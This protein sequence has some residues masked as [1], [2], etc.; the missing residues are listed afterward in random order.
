MKKEN[1]TIRESNFELL[2]IISMWLIILYHIIHHGNMIN[3]C[4]NETLAK[5]LRIIL[6]ATLVHVNSFVILTGY[7]QCKSNFKLKKLINLIFQ[8]LF[9]II[10]IYLIGLKLGLITNL[11]NI[12]LINRLSINAI[13][14]YW[15]ITNYLIL[16]IFSDYINKFL[17]SLTKPQLEKF[18]I[19]CFI[20]FSILPLESGG[21]LIPNDGFNF[22][23]FIY[24]Y[25]IG[26]YL[27]LYPLKD[28]KYLKK[29]STNKYRIVL[30]LGFL[31]CTY[32]NYNLFILSTKIYDK[33][34]FLTQIAYKIQ[35]YTLAYSHPLTIIQ[36][37]CYFEFFKT[38]KIKNIL[39]NF[40]SK[41]VLSIYLLHD[42]D[43]ARNN[44]YKYLNID[45]TFSNF[46]MLPYIFLILI[47][48]FIICI[49]IDIIRA[50]IFDITLK[51][52]IY[53]KNKF[54]KKST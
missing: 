33:N 51:T 40:I 32:L 17:Y 52:I 23:H 22:Y 1:Q 53:L 4:T 18:L 36:T 38:L 7:F 49:F 46:E 50:K 30:T 3:N 12:G 35:K 34:L 44:I 2:R 9:Y 10:I 11:N 5:T 13:G 25:I 42:S 21:R 54:T 43:I 47:L 26:A 29:L 28:N 45:K 16:Y 41:Y 19:I 48:I 6:Y 31:I 24:L 14:E 27:R 39:I 15:F 8:T 37:I 20:I